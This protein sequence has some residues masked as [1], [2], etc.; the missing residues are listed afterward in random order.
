MRLTIKK[1]V[2][3]SAVKL[4]SKVI[5]P[6]GVIPILSDFYCLVKSQDKQLIMTASD[7]WMS[8]SATLPLDE[9]DFDETFCIDAT[10]LSAALE[11][12]KEQPLS[13]ST[14]EDH[15]TL[16][17]ETG[18]FNFM[19]DP[20]EDYPLK[21]SG[22]YENEFGLSGDKLLAAMKRAVWA[23]ANDD[24]RPVMEGLSF[25]NHDLSFI[26]IAA[27]DGHVLVRT[28]SIRPNVTIVKDIDQF[29]M[30][31]KAVNILLAMLDQEFVHIRF[32][33]NFAEVEFK[34]YTLQFTLIDGKYPDVDKV[35]PDDQ[36]V[37]VS[38]NRLVLIGAL[39]KVIP[40]GFKTPGGNRVTLTFENSTIR[41]D[42][43]NADLKTSAHDTIESD[44][45]DESIR[46]AVNGNKLTQLL[47]NLPGFD[48]VIGMNGPDRAMTI[49]P[50][51]QPDDGNITMLIMPV[52]ISD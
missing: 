10:L 46:I 48:I 39:Q 37:K 45:D 16:H 44:Y 15:F 34:Q 27:S 50:A 23:T 11:R 26:A 33:T 31:K 21:E 7:S 20:T 17:H 2:L 12:L 52:V 14:N 19:L 28:S 40:F 24:L 6:K 5:N 43:E 38:T 25:R 49:Y 1:S 42:A 8:L 35:I 18:E 4:L 32:S 9:V 3:D 30:P 41:V 22:Q 47:K 13:L 51:E 36:P 29:I